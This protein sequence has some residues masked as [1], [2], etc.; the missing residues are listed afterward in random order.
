MS[1]VSMKI[2]ITRA[3]SVAS[4]AAIFFS[5]QALAAE[6]GAGEGDDPVV[7]IVNGARILKSEAVDAATRLPAQFEQFSPD[8]RARIVLRSLIDTRLTAHEARVRGFHEDPQYVERLAGIAEQLLER[9]FMLDSIKARLTD[10]ALKESYETTVASLDPEIEVHARHILVNTEA[11]ALEI[12]DE[13]KNDVDFAELAMARSIGPTSTAGG[14]LGYFTHGGMMPEFADAA[15]AMEVDETSRRPIQTQFG[16]HVIHVIDRREA[17]P[18]SFVDLEA[19]L[20]E[21]LSQEIGAGIIDELRSSATI[22]EFPEKLLAP[23]R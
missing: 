23:A 18:P 3:L 17:P 1:I 14:D 16:W 2:R 7:A 19:S 15:F 22:E 13:L 10:A 9:M 8:V 11:E 4:T 6:E 21:R 12:V 5:A 20:R